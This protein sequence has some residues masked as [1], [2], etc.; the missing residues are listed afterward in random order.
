MEDLALSAAEL[1]MVQSGQPPYDTECFWVDRYRV[2]GPIPMPRVAGDG[3]YEE[4]Y[5]PFP[6]GRTT[7]HAVR[8]HLG[9]YTVEGHFFYHAEALRKRGT[10]I[11]A[12]ASTVQNTGQRLLQGA[13]NDPV[14]HWGRNLLRHSQGRTDVYVPQV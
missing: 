4:V 5:T 12:Y 14:V 6:S 7:V 1:Q 11:N 3:G 2:F 10:K 8:G 13:F 9:L